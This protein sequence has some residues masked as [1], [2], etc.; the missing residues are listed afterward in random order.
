M[1]RRAAVV[2]LA[3]VRDIEVITLPDTQEE[4]ELGMAREGGTLCLR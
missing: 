2:E 1:G 3:R 4:G